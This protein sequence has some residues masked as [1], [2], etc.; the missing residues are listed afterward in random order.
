MATKAD[1]IY[2]AIA[3]VQNE[4]TNIKKDGDNPYF[5]SQYV[6]LEKLM[7]VLKPI[8]KKHG[9]LVIQSVT[10]IGENESV[11]PALETCI[12]KDN[13]SIKSTMLLMTKSQDP[14]AQGSAITYA[15]RYALMSIFGLVPSE[16][17]DDGNAASPAPIEKAMTQTQ[18]L[19]LGKLLDEKG[20]KSKED[21]ILLIRTIAGD[22]PLNTSAYA[23]LEKEI[24]NAQA[25]TLQDVL[26]E[27]K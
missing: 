27:A 18:W 6:T 14:Q 20:I 13:Q 12:H 17:D 15:R 19:E 11:K 10:Y 26:M 5:S 24:N 21:K 9:L 22:K 7:Q 25:D 3:A 8:L 2:T 1:S 16:S 23:R 4:V